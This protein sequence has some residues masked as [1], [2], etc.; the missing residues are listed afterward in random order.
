MTWRRSSFWVTLAAAV[1]LALTVVNMVLFDGNRTLQAEIST[2]A[3]YIQQTVQ[4]E[5]VNRELINALA[6]LSVR[7]KDEALR[8]VLSQHGITVNVSGSAVGSASSTAPSTVEA[9][10]RR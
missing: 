3:Q 8:T 9:K 10:A 7:N 1:A 4:I 2:R 5:A 6:N